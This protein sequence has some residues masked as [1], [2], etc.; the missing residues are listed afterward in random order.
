MLRRRLLTVPLALALGLG[1]HPARAEWPPR[2]QND[3]GWQLV[4]SAS[5]QDDLL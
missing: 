3:S 4:P 5:W 2:W 1:F